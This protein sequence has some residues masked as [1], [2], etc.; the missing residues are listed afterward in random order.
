MGQRSP[1][2]NT[3]RQTATSSR[4]MPRNQKGCLILSIGEGLKV[5]LIFMLRRITIKVDTCACRVFITKVTD[6][7]N[8]PMYTHPLFHVCE[9]G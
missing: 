3:S 6:K 8:A 4:S 1:T 5:D 7:D 9:A 2:N